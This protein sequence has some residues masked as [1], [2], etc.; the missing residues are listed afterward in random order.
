MIHAQPRRAVPVARRE[1]FGW[2]CFDFAN[3]AF[4]TI[5]IT[6]VGLPYFTAAIAGGATEAAGWWGTSISFAQ[7]L[8]IALSPLV[9]V[10]ADASA[11]KKQF[12]ALT[13]VVC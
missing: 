1:I 8:V 10:I 5:V 7:A 6:V 12:P 11:R 13:A 3:S 4:T 2:C 9:G